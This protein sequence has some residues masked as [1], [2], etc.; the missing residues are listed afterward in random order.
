[1]QRRGLVD[2]PLDV[3][4][5][6]REPLEAAVR[7]D[8]PATWT[9]LA[10]AIREE[11]AQYLRDKSR[12]PQ[13]TL[14]ETSAAGPDEGAGTLSGI[15]GSAG[16]AEGEVFLVLSSEDF[17]RFPKGAVLVARTTNPTWTPLFYGACA[18]IT[19]SGGPLSHGAVTAREMKIPAVMSVRESLS[20]LANGMRVRVDGSQGRVQLL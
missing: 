6:R 18:V 5:A 16:V 8:E 11:K 17:A 10:R 2:E 19:E 9:E 15:P 3:F 12:K 13:W 4:F 7:A 14:G 1:L 20:R